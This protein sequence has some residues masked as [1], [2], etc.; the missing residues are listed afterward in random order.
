MGNTK[1]NLC[2]FCEKTDFS[3]VFYVPDAFIFTEIGSVDLVD[4]QSLLAGYIYPFIFEFKGIVIKGYAKELKPAVTPAGFF[5][6][7]YAFYTELNIELVKKK[8]Y[9]Q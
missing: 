2:Q 8:D 5:K 4:R 9:E 3:K 1:N 6:K 7:W